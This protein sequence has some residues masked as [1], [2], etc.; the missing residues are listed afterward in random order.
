MNPFQSLFYFLPC[1]LLGIICSQYH[2]FF[3]R[4][5]VLFPL[6]LLLI[7]FLLSY[8]QVFYLNLLSNLEKDFFAYNGFDWKLIEKSIQAVS[9]YIIFEKFLDRKFVIVDYVAS[10]SFAIYFL[11]PYL[12]FL[13]KRVVDGRLYGF[14]YWSFLSVFILLVCLNISLLIKFF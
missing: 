2:Q 1:Y 9:I 13:I 7:S 6:F 3:K 4:V 14:F 11:H 10:T 8:Y 5:S 12:I